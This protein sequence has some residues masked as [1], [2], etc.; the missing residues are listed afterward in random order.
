MVVDFERQILLGVTSREDGLDNCVVLRREISD[1]NNYTSTALAATFTDIRYDPDTD[2]RRVDAAS[3]QR[4]ERLFSRSLQPLIGDGGSFSVL[5]KFPDGINTAL[6][7]TYLREY[8]D[9]ARHQLLALVDKRNGGLLRRAESRA[10][11]NGAEVD[12][13]VPVSADVS[14]TVPLSGEVS[15][16]V[17]L[18]VDVSRTAPLSV[19]ISQTATLSVEI[20]R[21]VPVSDEASRPAPASAG[22]SRP[23]PTTA[24][25]SRA[26]PT[27]AGASRAANRESPIVDEVAQHWRVA[28]DACAEFCAQQDVLC[29]LRAYIISNNTRALVLHGSFGSG[30]TTLLAKAALEVTD[31]QGAL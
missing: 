29:V 13:T 11:P 19:E 21:T 17:P 31:R 18:S 7:E 15:R 3:R 24:A 9:W 8:C 6:H 25:I 23:L 14:R 16:T 26:W 22:L 28:A 4:L 10:A 2:E 5:W 27:G 20:S 1:L 12:R 30:R